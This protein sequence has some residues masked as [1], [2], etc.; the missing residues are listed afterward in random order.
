MDY[1]LRIRKPDKLQAH[2]TFVGNL[3]IGVEQTQQNNNNMGGQGDG[4][5]GRGV[6]G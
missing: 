6:G 4:G 5:R 1:L 2:H 3:I